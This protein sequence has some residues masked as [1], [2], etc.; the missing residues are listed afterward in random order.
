MK[1][2]KAIL[3]LMI[4]ISLF[5]CYRDELIDPSP[6]PEEPTAR[7]IF[8]K[9]PGLYE[10]TDSTYGY[11]YNMRVRFHPDTV[12]INGIVTE[13]N[14]VVSIT[15]LDNQ[16]DSL[17]FRYHS[18]TFTSIP[19]RPI[20]LDDYYIEN[21]QKSNGSRWKIIDHTPVDLEVANKRGW[22]N[23]EMW[24]S[25]R[26]ININYFFEDGVPFGDTIK[27]QK[28]VRIAN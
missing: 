22:N 26:L 10:V 11:K 18:F 25:F 16:F 9:I 8:Y 1:L 20:M 12:R 19:A 28:A 14:D 17:S 27:V 13:I 6:R 5:S 21:V 15:N 23:G 2:L 24:I 4:L 7:E 3:P